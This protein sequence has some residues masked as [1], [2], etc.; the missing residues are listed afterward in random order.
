MSTHM[1]CSISTYTKGSVSTCVA[2]A[3]MVT[4]SNDRHKSHMI[5]HQLKLSNHYIL[6]HKRDDM[7]AKATA[8]DLDDTRAG[9]TARTSDSDMV[10]VLRRTV[11]HCAWHEQ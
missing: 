8:Q 6:T 1:N 4:S 5:T 11:T 10:N 7:R 2:D 3:L 9:T